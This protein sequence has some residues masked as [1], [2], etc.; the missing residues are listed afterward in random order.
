MMYRYQVYGLRVSSAL[1][2]PELIADSAVQFAA[3]QQISD[4][5]IRVAS[6]SIAKPTDATG[7]ENSWAS[8]REILLNFEEGGRFL[9]R[10]GREILVEPAVGVQDIALRLFLLG[11]V[12]ATLL[13]QRGLLVLH[14]SA[15]AIGGLA[16]AFLAEK[17]K[18]KS[19][20]A[21]A[22]HVRGHML[23]ADDIVPVGVDALSAPL[24]YPGFPQL[25][26][27]PE[28]AEQLGGQS[29]DLPRLL[30][31]Y[32]KRARRLTSPFPDGPLPL[33]AL[34]V[35]SDG[36]AERIEPLPARQAFMS[37]VQ[38]SFV[39]PLLRATSTDAAHFRQSS[40]LA[41][42]LPVRS[43]QRRRSLT[44]LPDVV[45]MVEADLAGR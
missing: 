25:K 15:V 31:D 43:L 13:H 6:I 4:L 8:P 7:G 3:D 35:L 21:A 10:N 1:E 45:R 2:L 28:A 26:L 34:Y 12:L 29:E 36:E 38:H 42:I 44:L 20:L 19:T 17:G 23:V 33:R 11:P 18:G 27:F 5:V 37:I 16:V 41:G 9:V 30:P 40:Q 32:D 39:L 14:A 24:T 22:F